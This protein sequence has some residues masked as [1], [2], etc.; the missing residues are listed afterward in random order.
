MIAG[1]AAAVVLGGSIAYAGQWDQRSA[2]GPASQ[3]TAS[4]SASATPSTSP[5]ATPTDSPSATTPAA[6]DLP[7]ASGLSCPTA[8]HTTST[9]P[10]TA[11]DLCNATLQIP[12]WGPGLDAC[13][14]GT[15]KLT[16][17]S[18]A[19]GAD[20]TVAIDIRSYASVAVTG[21]ASDDAAVVLSCEAGDPPMPQVIVVSRAAGGAL[22][23]VGQVVGPFIDG[24]HISVSDVRGRSDGSVLVQ[25]YLAVGTDGYAELSAVRQWRGYRL[26]GDS[27]TQ[28]SGSTS[29]QADTKAT[30]LTVSLTAVNFPQGSTHATLKVTVTN[31]GTTAVNDVS[32]VPILSDSVAAVPTAA[33][34]ALQPQSVVCHTGSIAP[35]ATWTKTITLTL[36]CADCFKSNHD[37]Y[38]LQLRLGD[39]R[40]SNTPI[41]ITAA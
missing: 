10:I 32:F 12:S 33:C 1:V 37:D 23:T 38:E 20:G 6:T 28:T 22:H 17:G 21:P 24:Q 30:P 41:K 31:S 34:D 19:A 5:S 14:H 13:P 4:P 8:G 9:G 39:Q 7:V 27:F 3:L 35:G 15:V 29:F 16:G 11:A 25:V 26:L 36:L 40:Y 2:P 18:R